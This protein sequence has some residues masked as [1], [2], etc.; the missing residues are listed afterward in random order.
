MLLTKFLVGRLPE[1]IPA[2]LDNVL[3]IKA[4]S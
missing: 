1:R 3:G 4:P 2:A